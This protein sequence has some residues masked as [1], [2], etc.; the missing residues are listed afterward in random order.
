MKMNK[1]LYVD[2]EIAL[3]MQEL[4]YIPERRYS[5]MCYS[6]RT[7]V[8]EDAEERFGSL[9]DDGY[10]ELTIEGGGDLP[11]EEVYD[12]S[13]KLT[14][15]YALDDEIYAATIYE[16]DRWL[17][18]V[19]KI[20]IDIRFVR[21]NTWEYNYVTMTDGL[22]HRTAEYYSTYENTLKSAVKDIILAIK[23]LEK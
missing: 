9:T 21:K 18:D 23:T 20:F 16:A 7:N 1:D 6:K 19:R 3:A 14:E 15:P 11:M 13:I 22:K 5:G 2:Y 10:Y 4:G 12:T 8:R 17:R